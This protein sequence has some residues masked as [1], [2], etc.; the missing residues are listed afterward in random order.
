M[1]TCRFT[2]ALVALVIVAAFQGLGGVASANDFHAILSRFGN[3]PRAE[4][5]LNVSVDTAV[6]AGGPVDVFF[7]VFG[8]DGTTLSSFAVRLN[9]AGFATTLSAVPPN[10][11][12]FGIGGGEPALVRAR[13]PSGGWG[14]TATLHQRESGNRL[15]VSIPPDRKSDGTTIHVGQDFTVHVGQI[16]GTA[17]ILIANVSA[18]DVVADVFLGSG[19]AA[20]TGR[21]TNPRVQPFTTWRV[22]LRPEDQNANLV[23]KSTGDVVVQLVVDTGR[24]E[25]LT[26]MPTAP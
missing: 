15:V 22:D 20:G 23:V 21:Y 19:G 4:A 17:S 6:L 5:Y 14:A 10:N 26:V 1:T 2:R 13:T 16:S 8:T 25:A 9:S 12:L 11:N 7:D 3:A 18:G 24:L